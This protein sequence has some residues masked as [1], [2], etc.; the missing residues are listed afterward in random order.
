MVQ[1]TI[2]ATKA[3]QD[4]DT[5]CIKIEKENDMLLDEFKQWLE[6]KNLAEK[7]IIQHVG[8]TSFYIN[9]YLLYSE[10]IPA[11]KGAM[12]ISGFLGYWFIKKAMWAN[13]AHIRANAASLKKFYTFMVE[14]GDTP[15]E[16][17]EILREDI[18][19]EMPEWLATM[20]RYDDPNVTDMAEVWGFE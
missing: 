17:L 7:T 18:K 10:I 6:K 13:E 8:N 15:P 1:N 14:R 20:R 16:D 4:C 12:E 2:P 5:D 11:K 3:V 19:E 9:R